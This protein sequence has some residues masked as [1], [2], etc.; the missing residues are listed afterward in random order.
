MALRVLLA[1]SAGGAVGA[2]LRWSAQQAL[3]PSDG[4]FPWSTLFVNVSGSALL[5]ALPALSYVVARPVLRAGLGSGVLGGYTTLSATSEEARA[6]VASGHPALAAAYLVGTLAACLL[7]VALV[8]AF[9]PAPDLTP[10]PTSAP[11]PDPGGRG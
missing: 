3:P 2:C 10:A 1:V 6:L 7:A 11:T 4:A 8:A 9:R 5:A